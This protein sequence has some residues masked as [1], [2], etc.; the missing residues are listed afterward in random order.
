MGMMDGH[1]V[2][3]VIPAHNEEQHIRQ[4]LETIP[5]FVDHA[6]V[7]DDG[8][9]DATFSVAKSVAASANVTILRTK[10]LGVGAAIDLG[11]QHL[12]ETIQKPFV[13][14]VMAGDGQMDPSDL[15]AIIR[16]IIEGEADHVKGNRMTTSED[17]EQM[18]KRRRRASRILGWLTTLASGRVV[19]DPQCGYTAT[20][21]KLLEQWNWE[22][23]WH[24]YGYPNYWL[25]HL[26][27]QRFRVV[28][29]PVKAVYGSEK[30]G[31]KPI[32]FFLKVGL[33]MSIE[34]HKRA[35]KHL[36]KSPWMMLSF[37][38]YIAG[39]VSIGFALEQ[40]LAFLG[41]PIGWWIA[42]RLDR[43]AMRQ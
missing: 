26:S 4:V 27:S 12:L 34:H 15:S 21:S 7:I 23:S 42:H 10:G 32:N 13:S 3:V 16:P 43:L 9:T 17:I 25:I 24:G 22:R 18:P 30:S 8:S 28:D 38:F 11:H 31:I 5:S 19:R 29:V 35:F 37:L 2:G 40:P 1:T 39:Y 14:V 36:P 33:M 20:S 6:V 41:L